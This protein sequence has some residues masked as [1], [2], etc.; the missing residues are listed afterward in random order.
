MISYL[1]YAIE[2]LK[3]VH[4]SLT[5]KELAIIDSS[6]AQHLKLARRLAI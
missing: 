6:D 2:E 5:E 1:L 3:E 4:H